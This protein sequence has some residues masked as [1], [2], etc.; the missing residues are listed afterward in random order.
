[1]DNPGPA[2]RASSVLAGL[3]LF[4]CRGV[5]P[6]AGSHGVWGRSGPCSLWVGALKRTQQHPPTNG[7][8]QVSFGV[9]QTGPAGSA[10]TRVLTVRHPG[11]A[12]SSLIPSVSCRRC[13]PNAPFARLEMLTAERQ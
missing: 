9:A 4:G 1:M 3:I 2:K 5:V 13:S 12:I 6:T 11:A 8:P 10:G 7:P